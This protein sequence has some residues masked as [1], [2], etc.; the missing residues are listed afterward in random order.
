M[1][2]VLGLTLESITAVN[3]WQVHKNKPALLINQTIGNKTDKKNP[4]LLRD[5]S[6][7]YQGGI[8]RLNGLNGPKCGQ[9]INVERPTFIS[10]SYISL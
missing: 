7:S 8:K 1:T 6:Y 5:L 2:E 4:Q 9:L 10:S 3:A